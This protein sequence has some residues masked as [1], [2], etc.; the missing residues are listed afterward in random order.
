MIRRQAGFLGK[1]V[2][3][4]A[5]WGVGRNSAETPTKPAI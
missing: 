4:G 5:L 2:R 1:L 3:A